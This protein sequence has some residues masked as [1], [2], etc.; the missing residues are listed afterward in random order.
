VKRQFWKANAQ[1][2]RI[3][4]SWASRWSFTLFSNTAA[5]SAS[6]SNPTMTIITTFSAISCCENDFNSTCRLIGMS[7]VAKTEWVV[8]VRIGVAPTTRR[9]RNNQPLSCLQATRG[10][11][12]ATRANQEMCREL[13]VCKSSESDSI[14]HGSLSFHALG[15]TRFGWGTL[16]Q[17]GCRMGRTRLCQLSRLGGVR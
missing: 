8:R 4:C 12:T 9:R 7:L 5:H 17:F 13:R 15:N 14:T 1:S 3:I 6:N 10:S 16:M 2:P 11:T